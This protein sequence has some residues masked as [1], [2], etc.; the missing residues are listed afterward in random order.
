MSEENQNDNADHL[1]YAI[2]CAIGCLLLYRI[3]IAIEAFYFLHRLQVILSGIAVLLF[4]VAFLF[5]YFRNKYIDFKVNEDKT[6][7]S[8]TKIKVGTIKETNKPLYIDLRDRHYHTQV[9][10]STGCGKTQ[11]IIIPWILNDIANGRGLIIIDGK[12]EEAFLKRLYGAACESGRAQD[13]LL[14]SLASPM[15]SNTYNP[16]ANG[17]PHEVAE[18]IFNSFSSDN[19][20]YGSLQFSGLNTILKLIHT[21]GKIPKPGLVLQLLQN[22]NLL[23]AWANQINDKDI[24]NEVKPIL[25]LTD[26]KFQEHFSGLL[27]YLENFTK[28]D[29]APLLNQ[30]QSEIDFEKIL[31]EKK[32]VYFQ[33][34]TLSSPTLAAT[35]GKL[36]LQSFVSVVGK[37]QAKSI[38]RD[39]ELFSLYLDDFNDYMYEGFV[40]VVNK[41]RSGGIGVVF[42]HQALSDLSKISQ[43]FKETIVQNTNNKIIFKINEPESASYFSDYIGTVTGEKMTERRTKGALGSSLDTG[44]K[45]VREAESY[46]QHPNTF[47]RKLVPFEAIAV[48][49]D[50]DKPRVTKHIVCEKPSNGA[51]MIN[52]PNRTFPALS[53]I[54]DARMFGDGEI[55]K[56]PQ[57]GPNSTSFDQRRG[58]KNEKQ[59]KKSA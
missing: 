16:L 3:G 41:T 46:E 51:K 36:I 48:I 26:E 39:D 49:L 47:K 27:A 40:S 55:N 34:P 30:D 1:L 9:I 35:L 59:T 22:K 29:V 24:F 15:Q 53:Y 43:E 25:N 6:G 45:S 52:P 7:P 13:F 12:P 11:G 38:L 23:R 4:S 10:G 57:G 8:G 32:I 19:S 18:R 31:H 17:S 33:L 28:S 54:H 56:P 42:S 2:G 44:E 5:L 50:G 14:F 37:L 20:Y 21:A 58:N